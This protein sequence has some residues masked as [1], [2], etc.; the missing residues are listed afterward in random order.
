MKAVCTRLR[1]F[2]VIFLVGAAT[3][4]L[5]RSIQ[6]CPAGQRQNTQETAP[7]KTKDLSAQF[8]ERGLGFNSHVRQRRNGYTSTAL[9]LNLSDFFYYRIYRYTT[10]VRHATRRVSDSLVKIPFIDRRTDSLQETVPGV[11][12]QL[13]FRDPLENV[14]LRYPWRLI[15]RR[16]VNRQDH[17]QGIRTHTPEPLLHPHFGAVRI[18]KMV[19]PGS[20]VVSQRVDKKCISFPPPDVV[21][22]P[23]RHENIDVLW[24]FPSIRPD[25]PQGPGP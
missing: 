19:E 24:K 12:G 21:S 9:C 15:Y 13:L 1:W 3:P 10:L 20:F 16:V 8:L 6:S 14:L 2:R 7:S 4:P 18:S 17:F 22:V 11:Q 5:P 23:G 25:F